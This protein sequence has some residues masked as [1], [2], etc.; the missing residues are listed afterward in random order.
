MGRVSQSNICAPKSL[1]IP[2]K[3]MSCGEV[4]F[5]FDTE[6]GHLAA[7]DFVLRLPQGIEDKTTLFALSRYVANQRRIDCFGG[8]VT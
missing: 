2:L 5:V 4:H 7:E 3:Y 6:N 1:N 8:Q